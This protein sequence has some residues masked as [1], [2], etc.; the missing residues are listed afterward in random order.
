MLINKGCNQGVGADRSRTDRWAT[1]GQCRE[2]SILSQLAVLIELICRGHAPDPAC[3]AVGVTKA[4]AGKPYPT[5]EAVANNLAALP[6]T[7]RRAA[8]IS[9]RQLAAS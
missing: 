6:N 3:H 5:A 7:G 8:T 4:S 9:L 2:E 1:L